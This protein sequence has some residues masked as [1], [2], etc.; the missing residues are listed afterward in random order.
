MKS[1]RAF[2]QSNGCKE[3]ELI[4]KIWRRYIWRHVSFKRTNI[5]RIAWVVLSAVDLCCILYTRNF[6][7]ERNVVLHAVNLCCILYTRKFLC[8][9][10]VVLHPWYFRKRKYRRNFERVHPYNF[11]IYRVTP[12]HKVVNCT[13]ALR[14]HWIMMIMIMWQIPYAYESFAGV[15]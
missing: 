11:T 15:W 10:N 7:C 8:E 3:I 2:I 5:K 6:L 14:D 12:L 1:S 9:R 4:L 13:V